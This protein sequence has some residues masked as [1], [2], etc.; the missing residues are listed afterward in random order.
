MKV[1]GKGY[2]YALL[3]GALFGI[4]PILV[5]N[6]S[7]DGSI[8]NSFCIMVRSFIAGIVLLPVAC[9]RM[10]N[11][12]LSKAKIR[13]CLFRS[14]HGEYIYFTFYVLSAHTQWNWSDIAL[15]I[16]HGRVDIKRAPFPC[17]YRNQNGYRN[18]HFAHWDCNAL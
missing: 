7:Q 6:I 11:Q 2:M 8:S 5:L 13:A 17:A 10:K 12:Q 1:S 4:I 9:S 15:Y 3:S 18:V 14:G 16:S